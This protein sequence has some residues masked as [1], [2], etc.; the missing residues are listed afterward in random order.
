MTKKDAAILSDYSIDDVLATEARH[1]VSTEFSGE[2]PVNFSTKGGQLSWGGV[3]IVGNKMLVVILNSIYEN[4]YYTDA[5]NASIT[6]APACFAF[7]TQE[8][9]LAPHQSVVELGLSQHDT[10]AGCTKNMWGSAPGVR[11]GKACQNTRRL[12][13]MFAGTYDG[14][15]GRD[16]IVDPSYYST[17]A[18]GLLKL[19]VTSVKAF[20]QFV[21]QVGHALNRPPLGVVTQVELKPHDANQFELAFMVAESLP[22]S[23]VPSVLARRDLSRSLLEQPYVI[24]LGATPTP[25]D[26]RKYS[27]G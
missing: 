1:A 25:P 8:N 13:L 7:N 4:V 16:I 22:D 27:N 2:S 6:S 11:L 21:F 12:L 5:Y 23:V 26:G 18:L 14:E 3:D 19:P 24:N 20:S 10:C 17:A 9:Q 15:G